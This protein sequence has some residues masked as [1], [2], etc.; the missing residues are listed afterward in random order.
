MS[1]YFVVPLLLFVAGI[2]WVAGMWTR[3]KA[4]RWCPDCGMTL[5]C[6]ACMGAGAHGL[7]TPSR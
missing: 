5:N 7:P 3:R 2:G 4:D 1:L 6:P